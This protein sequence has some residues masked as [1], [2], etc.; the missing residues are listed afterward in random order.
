MRDQDI[1]DFFEKEVF[2][3]NKNINND[4][5]DDYAE[6]LDKLWNAYMVTVNRLKSDG[7]KVLRNDTTGK[8]KVIK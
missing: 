3:N 7:Y 2:N 1:I 4:S 5:Q 6:E 8:H